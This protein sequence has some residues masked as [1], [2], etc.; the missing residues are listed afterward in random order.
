MLIRSKTFL[1][2]SLFP[3]K[4]IKLPDNSCKSNPVRPAV[5]TLRPLHEWG[6]RESIKA[7]RKAGYYH[8]YSHFSISIS[9]NLLITHGNYITIIVSYRMCLSFLS[10]YGC[11]DPE[12]NS[13]AFR[14]M[15]GDHRGTSVAHCC[16]LWQSSCEYHDFVWIKCT[17]IWK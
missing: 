17:V 14:G 10:Q 15:H 11:T 8:K 16:W 3:A 13:D 9:S 2:R 6:S 1:K 4:P 7:G 5:C 12:I